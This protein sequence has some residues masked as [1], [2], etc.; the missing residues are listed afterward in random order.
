MDLSTES[1][2]YDPRSNRR[3]MGSAPLMSLLDKQ[4]KLISAGDSRGRRA[5]E[6]ALDTT[7]NTGIRIG[8][9]SPDVQKVEIAS[10]GFGITS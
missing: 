6:G 2:L 7:A 10:V 1:T 3:L 5:I 4:G 9:T 8:G